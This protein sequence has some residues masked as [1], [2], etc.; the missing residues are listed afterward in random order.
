MLFQLTHP[1]ALDAL[2]R[3]TAGE[4]KAHDDCVAALV[5]ESSVV[6]VL[7]SGRGILQG[8]SAASLACLVVSLVVIERVGCAH[9]VDEEVLGELDGQGGLATTIVADQ[10]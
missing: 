1:L 7:G 6:S 4:V 10:D 2:E 9:A 8:D 5:G 3:G